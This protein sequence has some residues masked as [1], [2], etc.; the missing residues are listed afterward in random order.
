MKT[1]KMEKT[2]FYLGLFILFL[3][4]SYLS[5]QWSTQENEPPSLVIVTSHDPSFDR[6]T[7]KVETKNTGKETAK[8]VNIQFNL[9]QEGKLAES[10]VL[11]IDYV[12]VQSKEQGWVSF[13]KKKKPSDS[14]TIGS[15]TFLKP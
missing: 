8:S 10:S 11:E 15:I 9:F 13:S 12:P 5:Y 3:L 2:V 1:N 4:V 7:F 14:L 6:Y